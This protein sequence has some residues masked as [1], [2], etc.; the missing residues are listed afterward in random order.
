MEFKECSKILSKTPLFNN[1]EGQ[2]IASMLPCLN[3]RIYKYNKNDFITIAGD[4]FDG[5]GI[6]LTGHAEII[7]ETIS[8]NRVV[9]STL[10][11][12]EMF[13][14]M[15]AF[16]KSS[17]WP[18]SVRAKEACTAAFLSPEKIAGSCERACS[19]HKIIIQN[20]LK[21]ISDKALV[22]NKKVDY[23]SIKS[24]REKLSTYFYEQYK[25]TG[26]TTFM[27]PM[28]RN[29]LSD[30]LNVSR[31]SMSREMCRMRDEGIIDFHMSTIKILDLN[32]L[33]SVLE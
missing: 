19:F 22:L 8:G 31:P 10:E 9:M 17:K 26:K 30:F 33:T 5:I 13:G 14:E 6:L 20:M 2:D 32:A 1:I 7:K 27:M 18:A 29:E 11:P 15:I 3:T 16:S 28:K 24:M 4:D 21:I 12:G 25:K 23:L